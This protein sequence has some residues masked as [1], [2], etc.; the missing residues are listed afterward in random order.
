MM[1]T[2]AWDFISKEKVNHVSERTP[3]LME[4]QWDSSL[5]NM[6]VVYNYTTFQLSLLMNLQEYRRWQFQLISLPSILVER[7][8]IEKSKQMCSS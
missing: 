3:S 2:V 8:G 7:K 1:D 4:K 5:K 6:Y